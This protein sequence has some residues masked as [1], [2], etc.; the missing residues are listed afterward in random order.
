M[1][2]TSRRSFL[3]GSLAA[4]G[5]LTL[6]LAF[7]SELRAAV[8]AGEG[9]IVFAPN[10]FLRITPDGR[11]EF[12]AKHDEMGQGIHTGLAI[13]LS[14]ELEIDVDQLDVVPAPAGLEYN[15]NA[16][17]IQVTGG[18]TSTWTSFDQMRQAG[19]TARTMLVAAAASTWSV[20]ESDCVAKNGRV[21]RT[22]GSASLSYA[23]LAEAA[24]SVPVP[25]DVALKD[26][27]TF[28]RIGKP[29]H[30]VDSPAK[31]SGTALFSLDQKKPGML[32]AMVLRAPSFGDRLA[33]FDA[34]KAKA[35][36]GVKGV[37]EI[38]SG[39][40]VVADGFWTAK[41]GREA[42]EAKWNTGP[43]SNLDTRRLR[44]DYIA[45]SK[46]PGLVAR[47]DGDAS[48]ALESAD[49]IVEATYE[50]PFQAHAPMEPLSCMVELREDGGADIVTGSQM[51]GGDHPAAAARLGV[52][53]SKVKFTNSF[54]GGGFGRRANPA[55]DFTLEAIEVALAAR[56]LNAPIKTV[57]TREDDLQGGWYR[58]MYVNRVRAGLKDGKIQAWHHRVVGQSIAAGTAFAPLMIQ[59]GIDGTSVEG[60]SDM[61]HGIPNLQVELHTVSLA[62]PV[63]WW[64]SVGHSHTAFAKECF[65]DECAHALK[66]DPYELRRSLLDG[67]PRLL[68][69]LDLAAEK[70]NWGSKLPDGVGRGIAVHESFKGFA[71]HV[72]ECSVEDG[73]VRVHRIVCAIDC[74]LVINPDQVEAQLQG[75]A[76]FALSSMLHAHISFE[77]GKV[78]QSNFHDFPI[79]RMHEAPK[80]EVHIV[81]TDDEMGGIGEVGVPSVAPAVCEAIFQ[82]TG[83]RI[84]RLPVGDQLQS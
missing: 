25:A 38:P 39:I 26:P 72:A 82:A 2:Q 43:G 23:E 10:A 5:G 78:V 52:D 74:G 1:F 63:Q 59:N 68:R 21:E 48:R 19:A 15:H 30:R 34:S 69:V 35:M 84:R 67:H 80:V 4:G 24:A 58:P 13:A 36:P 18:S 37:Y 7:G 12:I 40:A 64:R 76:I 49:E 47:S 77:D 11:V 53:P 32:T 3:K 17:G 20:A 44:A 45:R 28:T 71:A 66:Q 9:S 42:I 73:E 31:V 46:T 27:K 75:A 70:S 57:W 54:L 83:R 14:E 41:Q 55:S 51:L 65:L 22:D 62:V 61:P 16:F 79:M 50:V 6:A 60:V 29:T 8:L 81:K 56:E 33:S